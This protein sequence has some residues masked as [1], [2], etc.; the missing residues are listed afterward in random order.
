MG[1][2]TVRERTLR[3]LLIFVDTFDSNH[4]LLGFFVGWV[5]ALAEKTE[6]IVVAQNVGVYDVNVR[7]INIDKAHHGRFA[8]IAAF[9]RILFAERNNYDAVLIVMAPT[10]AILSAPFAKF[11]NKKLYLWYAVWKGTWKLKIAEKLVDRIFCSVPEAFPFFSRKLMAIGQGIDTDKFIP[12]LSR[13]KR[14]EI[15]FLGRLS[16]VKKIEVLLRAFTNG[17]LSIVGGVARPSDEIYVKELRDLADQLGISS[18]I[19]W[20][21]R[22][23]HSEARFWYQQ[24]DIFV[25]LTP[26]GSFDKTMLE[27]MACGAIVLA[28][29]KALAHFLDPELRR[30]LIF[31]KGNHKSL[32]EHLALAQS[33]SDAERDELRRKS[34][35]VIIQHHSQRQWTEKFLQAIR[36]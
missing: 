1:L 23:P 8:R 2:W 18:N 24:A 32:A 36:Q 13:R 29:N 28:S 5:R 6:V 14:G 10:W 34:R 9:T 15:L 21:D 16:P 11:F 3:R 26:S 27:A 22:V 19:T 33:L 17:H 30:Y 12:D 25:N 4:D 7:V 35:D 31:E 20:H